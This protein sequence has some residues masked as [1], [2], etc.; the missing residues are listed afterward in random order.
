MLGIEQAPT[1]AQ[2]A[3]TG[4]PALLVAQADAARLPAADGRVDLA[5]ASMSLLDMDDYA[6]AIAETARVLR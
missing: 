3:A 1:L 2:A 4:S 6:G 5:V